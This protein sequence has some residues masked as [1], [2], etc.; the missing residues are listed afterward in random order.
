M[1]NEIALGVAIAAISLASIAIG[2]IIPMLAKMFFSTHKR[3]YVSPDYYAKMKKELQG[4]R[5]I[6]VIADIPE[7]PPSD[8][9]AE[10]AFRN[11]L[12]KTFW[13]NRPEGGPLNSMNFKGRKASKPVEAEGS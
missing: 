12:Q 9:E 8:D 3:E 2:L 7:I 6:P 10:V 13:G 11:N 4:K 5:D 1:G